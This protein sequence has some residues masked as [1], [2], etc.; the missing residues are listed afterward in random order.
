MGINQE[1]TI[2][3]AIRAEDTVAGT[4]KVDTKAAVADTK[5]AVATKVAAT[6]AAVADMVAAAV[7]DTKAAEV[8]DISREAT[9]AAVVAAVAAVATAVVVVV[10]GKEEAT[11]SM[12]PRFRKIHL[13][14]PSSATFHSIQFKVSGF[15]FSLK[16]NKTDVDWLWVI[17]DLD[18]FF[19]GLNISTLA[20]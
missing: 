2:T 3:V 12:I 8:V 13:L 7:A 15:R 18:T 6:E 14:R 19:A 5:A 20:N 1:A 17:G 9:V 10:T 16:S 11:A 4:N